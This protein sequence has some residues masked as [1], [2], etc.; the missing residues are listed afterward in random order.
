MLRIFSANPRSLRAL[1][2]AVALGAPMTL[3][4]TAS[5]DR[6]S[7][8]REHHRSSI[9]SIGVGG[10]YYT[11]TSYKSAARQIAEAFCYAGYDAWAD[12]DT[13]VIRTRSTPR[14]HW[15]G[16][17][18]NLRRYWRGD[19]LI[20]ELRPNRHASYT[21][22]DVYISSPRYSNTRRTPYGDQTG[23]VYISSRRSSVI[24]V[25]G[26]YRDDP[27]W[28]RRLSPT[29]GR[30]DRGWDRRWDN[31]CDTGFNTRWNWKSRRP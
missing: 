10:H 4:S 2:A 3:V 8:Y 28:G 13:V 30:Y 24:T 18:Y 20:L 5:A 1:V 23:G 14:Y 11:I 6:E 12:Y 26:G 16:H 22:S 9:G 25:R 7:P 15:K 29:R 21:R 17:D 19:C 27:D 31:S